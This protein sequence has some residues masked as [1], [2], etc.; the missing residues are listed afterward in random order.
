MTVQQ[1]DIAAA[2]SAAQELARAVEGL[3]RH[4]PDG[5]DLQ[6]LV[7]DAGRISVD[8]DLLCGA[9]HASSAPRELEVI[10][11]G[12]YPAEFWADAQD[13]GVGRQHDR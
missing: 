3:R 5:V 6:R 13:E 1:Q 2:R 12:D 8:L 9:E 10:P 7:A 11:D 4:Y